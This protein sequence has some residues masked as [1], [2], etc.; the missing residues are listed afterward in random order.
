MAPA[1]VAVE[2]ATGSGSIICV[3]SQEMEKMRAQDIYRRAGMNAS[4]L[5]WK[6]VSSP[7]KQTCISSTL[8]VSGPLACV[9]DKLSSSSELGVK[10]WVTSHLQS[11][12]GG[13]IAVWYA[14][15]VSRRL[16]ELGRMLGAK[17]MHETCSARICE[18]AAE[19]QNCAV[20]LL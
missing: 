19:V 9:G 1:R 12:R 11:G 15:L 3:L 18:V 17:E 10:D 4:T 13:T 2:V 20:P 16:S 6:V 5:G 14:W 8:R 7:A